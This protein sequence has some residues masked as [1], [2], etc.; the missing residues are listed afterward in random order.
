MKII[1]VG[2]GRTG[3]ALIENL[4]HENHDIVAI[5]KDT[6]LVKEITDKTTATGIVGSGASKETLLDAGADRADLLIAL[7]QVDEI[8]LLSCMQAKSLGTKR[9]VARI[10]SP[11][12]VEERDDLKKE[13]NIDYL[14]NPKLDIAKEM[15]R[16]V[17]LPGNVKME[18]FFDGYVNM[19]SI[20]IK[21]ESEVVGKTLAEIQLSQK[22][23]VL[24]C[25][26]VR[27]GKLFIPKGDFKLEAGDCLGIVASEE[28]M[29]RA[30]KKFGLIKGNNKDILIVGGGTVSEYLIQMLLKQHKNITLIDSNLDRCRKYMD[31]YENVKVLYGELG[32]TD[33][34]E[35]ENLND[36]DVCISLSD[37]D[38]TNLVVSM[39]AWALGIKSI[40]TKVEKPSS[41][42]L[43]HKVNMDITFSAAEVSVMR[44]IR[45]IRN[46]AIGDA[47]NEVNKYYS[48]ADKKAQAL[49]INANSDSC[50][51]Y[52]VALKEKEFA[53]KK[54]IT[55]AAI[56]RDN[57]LIIPK[58]DDCIKKNDRVIVVCNKKHVINQLED[59]FA[60]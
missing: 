47:K 17:G 23:N 21:N 41:V 48:I 59:I 16:N 14:I 26:V 31:R 52:D 60:G 33:L 27:N 2:L 13:Y 36:I 49:E 40:L 54:G 7:T 9:T 50:T 1:V 51:K 15:S 32:D 6:Y 8:N 38:E 3:C 53:L 35:E 44:L 25:T 45:F 58:G 43:L 24:I 19:A 42:K 22:L 12:F 39:Y 18:C 20:I 10:M 28:D 56:I 46:T 11:D 57:E 34:L 5:D 37:K 55:I 30:L 29:R 4:S